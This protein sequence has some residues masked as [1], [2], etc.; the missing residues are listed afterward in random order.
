M[1]Y[2]HKLDEASRIWDKIYENMKPSLEALQQAEAD[3]I[4]HGIGVVY[5]G[6]RI[7]PEDFFAPPPAED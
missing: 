2:L 1:D 4:K 7:A 6:Q 5:G 3:M